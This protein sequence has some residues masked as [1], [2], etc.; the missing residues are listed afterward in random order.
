MNGDNKLDSTMAIKHE[1]ACVLLTA[2]TEMNTP[3]GWQCH[4][5]CQQQQQ[6]QQ[7]QIER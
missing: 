5:P 1:A 2:K 4:L 3:R 7:Q 6:Q